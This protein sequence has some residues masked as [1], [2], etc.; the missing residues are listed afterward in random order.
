MH[1]KRFFN[2]FIHILSYKRS[3]RIRKVNQVL[4]T[5]VLQLKLGFYAYTKIFNFF[6]VY[7]LLTSEANVL[8]IYFII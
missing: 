4:F 8:F 2:Y 7:T 3:I 1:Y 5:H 6:H